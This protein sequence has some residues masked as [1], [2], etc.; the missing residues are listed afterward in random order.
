TL[1]L[2]SGVAPLPGKTARVL[3]ARGR[4]GYR[5]RSPQDPPVNEFRHARQGRPI[6]SP[7]RGAAAVPAAAVV[8]PVLLLPVV[9][10]LR[11]AAGARCDGR[12]GRRAGGVSGR[13]GGVGECP[14]LGPGR[15]DPA[16]A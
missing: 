1:R 6:R 13:A 12:L 2:M 15:T 5:A 3:A 9:G 8:V 16:V 10:L 7:A 14:R 11:A 4:V